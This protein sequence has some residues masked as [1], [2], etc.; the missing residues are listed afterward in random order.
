M[1]DE[2][3]TQIGV[4]KALGYD[5]KSI[6]KKYVFYSASATLIGGFAGFIAGSYAFPW[7]IWLAYGMMYDFSD[8]IFVID[9]K[10]GLLSILVALL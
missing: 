4:L 9:W 8:I 7:V 5:K 10:L 6:L 1:V 3:R 2:Q